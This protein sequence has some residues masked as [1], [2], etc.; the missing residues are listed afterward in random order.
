M[1][2]IIVIA[3]VVLLAICIVLCIVLKKKK[4]KRP[5]VDT[6]FLDLLIN[7]F[8]GKDNIQSVVVDNARLKILVKD[9]ALA[10]LNKLKELSAQGV[11]ITGNYIKILFKYDSKVIQKELEK[12]I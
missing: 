6:E 1:I 3:A 10:D 4:V 2:T 8:G 11:F 12:R 5:K 7:S 9:V